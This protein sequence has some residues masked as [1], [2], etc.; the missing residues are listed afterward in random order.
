[1]DKD[2]VKAGNPFSF[3]ADVKE[4]SRLYAASVATQLSSPLPL[5]VSPSLQTSGLDLSTISAARPI[6]FSL[7]AIGMKKI[8]YKDSSRV[9]GP[10][11]KLVAAAVNALGR[12]SFSP[13]A[14]SIISVSFLAEAAHKT[15]SRCSLGSEATMSS[16]LLESY[17]KSLALLG[18]LD[19]A[20]VVSRAGLVMGASLREP[21]ALAVVRNV[22]TLDELPYAFSALRILIDSGKQ[23]SD[24]TQEALMDLVSRL[25]RTALPVPNAVAEA[26]GSQTVSTENNTEKDDN[27]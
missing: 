6:N 20:V 5:R 8:N 16:R 11:S 3:K 14:A 7:S 22:L 19:S 15:E 12:V 26:I 2:V 23:A 9:G 13:F 1:V 21:T 10:S 4:L 24:R 17:V 18:H 27:R 25:S